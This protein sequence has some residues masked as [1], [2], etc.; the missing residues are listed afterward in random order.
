MAGESVL[1]VDDSAV[2]LKRVSLVLQHEGYEVRTAENAEDALLVMAMRKPRLIL[3]DVR[4]PG[5]DGLE[6][7]RHLRARSATKDVLI[8]AVSA[9]TTEGDEERALSAGCDGYVEKP[10]DVGSLPGVIA[11]YLRAKQ[12]AS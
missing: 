9:L 8:L 1:I 2:N 10:I 11:K 5:M 4:L 3:M 12:A 6:L 7:T